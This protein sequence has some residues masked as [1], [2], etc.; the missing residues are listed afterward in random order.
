MNEKKNYD[1]RQILER[2]KAF[3]N[4]YLVLFLMIAVLLLLSEGMD[5]IPPM[6]NYTFAM[7]SLWPSMLVCFITLIIKDAYDGISR[8]PGRVAASVFGLSGTV[9]LVVSILDITKGVAMWPLNEE[10]VHLVVGISCLMI[11]I[12]YWVKWWC[13]EKRFKEA[14][15]E[16]EEYEK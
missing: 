4:G 12:V 16:E 1:E 13:N 8:S 6:D 15:K 7:L 2:G 11:C 3:R 5:I 14:E 10:T 9:L